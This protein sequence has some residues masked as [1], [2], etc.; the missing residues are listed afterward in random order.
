MYKRTIIKYVL[1][2]VFLGIIFPVAAF[3]IDLEHNSFSLTFQNIIKIHKLNPIHFI[4]DS[5]P[6]I[7]AIVTY[8]I[9]KK[10]VLKEVHLRNEITNQKDEILEDIE[11][12][13]R[14]QM[15]LSP[16]KEFLDEV[17][18]TYFVMELP[19]NIVGGDFFWVKKHNGKII[20]ACADCTGHGVSGALMHMLCAALL[21]EIINRGIYVTASDILDQTRMQIIKNLNQKM[22]YEGLSEGMDIALCIFDPQKS[23]MEYAGA[24]NPIYIIRNNELIELKADKMPLGLHPRYSQIFSS[25]EIEIYKDDIIYL[26]SDGYADQFGGP[27]YSRFSYKKFKNLLLENHELPL[28]QQKEI[29]LKKYAFLFD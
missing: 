9:I 18:K 17:L 6:L 13:K 29:L 27:N 26:F 3:L 12:A 7:L 1:Y 2:S 28:E 5:I 24:Y 11:N 14:L 16:R 15:A 25:H 23:V 8:F 22:Q 4:I 19:R 21:N 10:L 20:V